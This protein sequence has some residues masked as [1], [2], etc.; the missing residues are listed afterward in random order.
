[1]LVIGSKLFFAITKL[2]SVYW[3]GH[4]TNFCRFTEDEEYEM[5][6]D[7]SYQQSSSQWQG[8]EDEDE[9]EGLQMKSCGKNRKK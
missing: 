4:L 2:L 7:T 5:D 8:V 1:M 3:K 9:E 6:Q